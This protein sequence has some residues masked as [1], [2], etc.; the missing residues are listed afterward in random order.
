M[1]RPS[2]ECRRRVQKHIGQH[3]ADMA[4]VKPTVSTLKSGGKTRYRFTFR[5]A[6][7]SSDGER[8][9]QIVHLT[10]DEGGEVLKVAVSR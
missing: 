8:Y 2:K 6:L 10:T 4:D 1:A 7:R 5:K 3:F 9:K